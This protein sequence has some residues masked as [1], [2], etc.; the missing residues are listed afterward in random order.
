MRN[1]F[2]IA[3]FHSEISPVVSCLFREIWEAGVWNQGIF[4]I[5]FCVLSTSYVEIILEATIA[6]VFYYPDVGVIFE[7][8]ILSSSH[9]LSDVDPAGTLDLCAGAQNKQ[10]NTQN[11]M[12]EAEIITLS[13]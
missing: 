5:L 7:K 10:K 1:Q 13:T 8:S 6:R 9:K 11:T 4:R 3:I 2:V 12:I